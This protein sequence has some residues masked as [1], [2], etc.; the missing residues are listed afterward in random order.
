MS[1]QASGFTEAEL[2]ELAARGAADLDGASATE[3]LRWTDETFGDSYV[4]AR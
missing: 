3:L 2:R 1:D 4:V